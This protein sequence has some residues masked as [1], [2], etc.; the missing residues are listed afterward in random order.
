MTFILAGSQTV[1]GTN[2]NLLYYLTTN[3]NGVLSKVENELREKVLDPYFKLNK[4]YDV[5]KIF[6]YENMMELDY[7]GMC[8]NETLRI[9]PPLT[10][11]SEF[12]F[13]QDI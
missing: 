5:N 4:D 9:S 1:R 13:D 11:S 10:L 3:F 8:V 7:M 12:A 6:N 2:V